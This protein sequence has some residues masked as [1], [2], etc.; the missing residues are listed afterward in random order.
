[1]DSTTLL[2][3]VGVGG[4]LLGTVVG[5]VGTLGA[6]R[7]TSRT[8]AAG[9]E[10]KARREA[11]SACATACQVRR[12][13]VAALLDAF[14]SDGFD[15]GSVRARIQSIDEQREAVAKAVGAVMIEGPRDV[16]IRATDFGASG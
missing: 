9:E 8:Q 4:T 12:D 3:V 2:G 6:A 7:I 13:A 1:M 16:A 10:Q 11:Y 14:D 5:A 15:M